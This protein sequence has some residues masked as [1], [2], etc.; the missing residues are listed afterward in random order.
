MPEAA[1]MKT[2]P[3]CAE[4][5]LAVAKKCK[6]CGEY[7]DEEA[8]RLNTPVPSAGERMLIP[9]GRPASAIASGYLALIGILPL[10]GLPFSIGAIITGFVALNTIKKKPE[11]SGSVRA[12]FGI[13][14]GFIEIGFAV[15]GLIMILTDG[16]RRR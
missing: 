6:Y 3:Y 9:V 8:R 2:C 1:E 5:I 15:F 7:L 10:F 12:W 14:L 16:G 4:S 11:M 13:I